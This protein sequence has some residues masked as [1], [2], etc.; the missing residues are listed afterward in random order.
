[1]KNKAAS[2]YITA[3]LLFGTNGVVVSQIALSSYEIVFTRTL[4]GALF[5]VVLFVFSKQEMRFG[6]NRRHSLYLVISGA[7]MGASWVFLFEAY[8][9]TGVSTATLASA[10]SCH[11]W[12]SRPAVCVVLF[13][14]ISTRISQFHTTRRGGSDS[15]RRSVW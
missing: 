2:K 1:M 11:P 12:L 5:L 10:N 9:Q 7:A 3:L 6:R 4:I 13:G 15:R 14:S 8:K